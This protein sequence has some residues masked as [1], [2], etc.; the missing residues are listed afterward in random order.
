MAIDEDMRKKLAGHV[1]ASIA[2]AGGWENLPLP[3]RVRQTFERG[4]TRAELDLG[5]A[6]GKKIMPGHVPDVQLLHTKQ[7]GEEFGAKFSVHFPYQVELSSPSRFQQA[8]AAALIKQTVHYA[9]GVGAKMMVL[10]PTAVYEGAFADPYTGALQNVPMHMLCKDKKEF[11]EF[12]T[13]HKVREGS[14]VKQ[15]LNYEWQNFFAAQSAVMQQQHAAAAPIFKQ[16]FAQDATFIRPAMRIAELMKRGGGDFTTLK[17]AAEAEISKFA[18][19]PDPDISN[20]GRQALA[21]FQQDPKRMIESYQRQVQSVKSKNEDPVEV[22]KKWNWGSWARATL[23]V[24][25]SLNPDGTMAKTIKDNPSDDE[26]LSEQERNFRDAL[27][28]DRLT[29]LSGDADKVVKNLKDTFDM[30]LSDSETIRIIKEKGLKLTL[31]NLYGMNVETGWMQ[32]AAFYTRPEH[33]A[34]AMAALREVAKKHGLSDENIGFTFDTEHATL[35]YGDPMKF[36]DELQ[37]DGVKIDHAHVVGGSGASAAHIFSHKGLGSMDD[38][39]LRAHPGLLERLVDMGVPLTIEPGS[40]GIGDVED[41]LKTFATGGVPAEALMGREYP[42]GLEMQGYAQVDQ[43]SLQ[44]RYDL[45]QG[46]V[47][48]ADMYSLQPSMGQPF[49]ATFGSLLSP[50]LYSGGALHKEGQ[51][52]FWSSN[53]PLLYSSKSDKD[54]EQ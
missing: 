11:E 23:C 40:G 4:V 36:V 21:R 25:G 41:A 35:G 12:C 24:G 19:S 3:E 53:Q 15:Q 28:R 32:G 30:A 38:E 54:Q 42:Q 46:F 7:L 50:S 31:E 6:Y 51:A 49:R 18:N 34:K 26:S 44:E 16:Q 1:G 22:L 10:H 48:K 45:N 9:A 29:D 17:A 39:I 14:A 20:I 27:A 8:E 5:D 43:G 37:K 47:N 13:I 52:A 2:G 33:I